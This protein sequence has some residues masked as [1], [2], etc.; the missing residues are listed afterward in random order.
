MMLMELEPRQNENLLHAEL[1]PRQNENNDSDDDFS[2][3]NSDNGDYHENDNESLSEVSD[4]GRENDN[5]LNQ[6]IN[7]SEESRKDNCE[8]S[9]SNSDEPIEV[10][11]AF[12]RHVVIIHQ[13][14]KIVACVRTAR[15]MPLSSKH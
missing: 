11:D 6:E 4:Q 13:N 1:E 9:S 7:S 2:L 15:P 10:G 8:K 12:D 5:I 14:F 3:G